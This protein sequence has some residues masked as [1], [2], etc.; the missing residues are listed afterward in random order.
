MEL[1][2]FR[3]SEDLTKKVRGIAGDERGQ[4]IASPVK[5]ETYNAQHVW[6]TLMIFINPVVAA[7]PEH[8][9]LLSEFGCYKPS[10]DGHKGRR[11]CG[12]EGNVPESKLP[13]SFYPLNISAEMDEAWNELVKKNIKQK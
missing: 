7:L 3:Y 13:A 5:G 10:L 1:Y 12:T 8:A 2:G 9:H 4:K 11:E 6:G